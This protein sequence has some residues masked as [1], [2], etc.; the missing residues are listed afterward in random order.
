MKIEAATS[1]IHIKKYSDIQ[2]FYLQVLDKYF[3][4]GLKVTSIINLNK[5]K[6]LGLEE[7]TNI[8]LADD[9]MLIDDLSKVCIDCGDNLYMSPDRV[10]EDKTLL[11]RVLD[12]VLTAFDNR[13]NAVYY[14]VIY[15]NFKEQLLYT[16]VY[17]IDILKGLLDYYLGSSFCIKK[18]YIALSNDTHI[19]A[20]EEIEQAIKEYEAPIEKDSIMQLLPH[21]SAKKIN[22]V[23]KF[24]SNILYWQKNFYWHINRI[25]ITEQER[26]L[27]S[28]IIAFEIQNGFITIKRLLDILQTSATDFMERNNIINHVCLRDILK[29]YFGNEFGFKYTFVGKLGEEMSGVVAVQNFISE[30]DSFTLSELI[31]FVEENDLPKQYESFIDEAYKNFIRIDDENFIRLEK[32]H[33]DIVVIE[34]VVIKYLINGYTPIS[35]IDSF[36]IFPDIGVKW[37]SFL[38]ENIIDK[39]SVRFKLLSFSRSITKTVGV[40]VDKEIGINNY[41]EILVDV[42]VNQSKIQSFADKEEIT[43]YLYDNGYLAQRRA[44]NIEILFEIAKQQNSFKNKAL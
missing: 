9:K 18:D 43:Q 38:L 24:N 23:L 31:E 42:I 25:E 17:N 5:F 28:D 35:K 44:K 14:D 15:C 36:S 13:K 26:Y 12:F 37:N 21:I 27:I 32:V 1:Y 34:N 22:D 2:K 8:T 7:N 10:I 33:F 20:D 41:E 39:Y 4:N 19:S 30:K 6:R 16:N 11:V 29:C 40:I 3:P